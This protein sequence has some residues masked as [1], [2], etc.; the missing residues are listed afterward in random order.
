MAKPLSNLTIPGVHDAAAVTS[1]PSAQTQCLPINDLLVNSIRY[2]D[3]RDAYPGMYAR[4]RYSADLKTL[5]ACHG[6]AP[7]F[8]QAGNFSLSGLPSSLATPPLHVTEEKVY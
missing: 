4:V 3:L 6:D 8:D 7:L 2:L 5:Y 1:T